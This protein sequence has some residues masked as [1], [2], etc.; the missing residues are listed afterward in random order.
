MA[1]QERTQEQE[2][3]EKQRAEE[4]DESK[5]E[6]PKPREDYK[7]ILREAKEPCRRPVKKDERAHEQ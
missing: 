2:D 3:M 5:R 1:E 6:R 7:V 4:K